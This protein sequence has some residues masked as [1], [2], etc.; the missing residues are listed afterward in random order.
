MTLLS[1]QMSLEPSGGSEDI[2]LSARQQEALTIGTARLSNGRSIRLLKTLLSSACERDC[3]YCPFRASR[4]YPRA[5]FKPELFAR[6]FF[7]L[8]SGGLVD[9]L[10][11]SSGVFNG[12]VYTQD[13]L[14]DTA[15]ILRH[16]MDYRGYLHIKLMPGVQKGQVEQAMLLADRVSVNLE[17]PNE[18]RLRFL[19][20]HKD[21]AT[22]LVQLLHWVEEI[23]QSQNPKL[24]WKGRWP[25]SVTQFVVGAAGES[26]RELLT[27]TAQLHLQAGL[28]RAYFS[29]FR[30]IRDTPLEDHPPTPPLRQQRLY[31]ASFLLRDYGFTLEE[32]PF[33]ADGDLPLAMDPKTA[34]AKRNLRERPVEVNTA[35]R[36][37]LLR[38]PGIGPRG[39][40][41]L[42]R[43]RRK[44]RL[45]EMCQLRKLGIRTRRAAPY[46]LL[47]GKAPAR[48]LRF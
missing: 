18:A 37:L 30:P 35:P 47:D 21:F 14:L 39:V 5:T 9:G 41:A 19:A 45:R 29:A 48:Q 7:A 17:A 42:L 3:M 20:P 8:Y 22:E 16:K 6:S 46:L 38:V 11:L 34:W 13:H 10:F 24:A 40:E 33:Q 31:Q 36:E 23:R 15:E 4:D 25:S 44:K 32:L 1:Q 28:A 12:G 2:T 43:A 26:D 27:V